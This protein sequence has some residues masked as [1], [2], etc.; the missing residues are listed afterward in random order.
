MAT[1][2]LEEVTTGVPALVPGMP[3][4]ESLARPSGRAIYGFRVLFDNGIY[5]LHYNEGPDV[6]DW[7]VRF[8]LAAAID[9]YAGPWV[10][11]PSTLPDTSTYFRRGG[12]LHPDNGAIWQGTMVKHRGQYY[13]YYEAYHSI[14]DVDT[15][16]LDYADR[17]AGSR[18]GFATA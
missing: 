5:Y 8:V 4:H 14:G 1:A 16:Y 9:P 11:S 7:P 2:L 18:V 10:V 13:L 12:A 17:Q 6:P 15:P 3:V